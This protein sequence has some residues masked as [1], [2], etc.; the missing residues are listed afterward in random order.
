MNIVCRALGV[1]GIGF[2]ATAAT[3]VAFLL[4]PGVSIAAEH[5]GGLPQLNPEK[6][7]T[8]VVWLALLFG[9]FMYLMVKRSL[10]LVETVIGERAGRVADG[11]E[12][13]GALSEQARSITTEFEA[14]LT[15]SH[16]QAQML[17]SQATEERARLAAEQMT[18]A[19]RDIA[20]RLAEVE[21]RIQSA[22]AAAI[23]GMEQTAGEVVVS[24]V[25]KIAGQTI[26]MA[27]AT[28]S[29]RSLMTTR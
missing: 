12:Q 3:A 27:D 1:A 20:A 17:L 11:L 23:A 15:Q 16:G 18:K 4:W 22:R 24:L 26:P 19:N 5:D 10:P 7:A 8:Q 2:W 13:A 14:M 9:A 25:D 28:S 29:I 21:I 6:V